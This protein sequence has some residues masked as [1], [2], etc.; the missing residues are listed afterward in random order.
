MAFFTSQTRP[1]RRETSQRR[2]PEVFLAV[3]SLPLA[4]TD[5]CR[6]RILSSLM[7]DLGPEEPKKVFW[8][9]APPLILGSGWPCHTPLSEGLDLPLVVWGWSALYTAI[10]RKVVGKYV[11]PT[12]QKGNM[13]YDQYTVPDTVAV[14]TSFCCFPLAPANICPWP[15]VSFFQIP[16]K[17]SKLKTTHNTLRD[18]R[19]HF[20]RQPFSK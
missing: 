20:S 17:N 5:V 13:G 12:I 19:V 1:L 7:A 4:V 15:I 8:D 16:L 3:I 10:L 18:C 6:R 14:E 9:T 2:Q 11:R